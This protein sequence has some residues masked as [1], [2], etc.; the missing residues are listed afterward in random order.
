MASVV[1]RIKAV[2]ADV[3]ANAEM[4]YKIVDGDGLGVFKIS[5]DRD[6]QEGIITIQ[7]VILIFIFIF[8]DGNITEMTLLR[9]H[10]CFDGRMH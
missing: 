7:K 1:A 5:V 9:S 3:G 6:T 10:V 2:D 4:E 8:F